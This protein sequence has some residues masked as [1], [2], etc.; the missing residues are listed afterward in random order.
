MDERMLAQRVIE[1]LEDRKA[2]DIVVIDLSEVSIPTSYFVVATADNTVHAK[3]LTNALRG[4]VTQRPRHSEGM[5]DRKWIVMDYGDIVVHIF[6]RD[7]RDFYDISSL[8][9]DRIVDRS[10]LEEQNV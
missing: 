8:W 4:G 1:V 7:A 2:E 10:C 6:D 9:A 3:A 5:T